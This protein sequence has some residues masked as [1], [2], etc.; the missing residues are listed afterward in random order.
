MCDDVDFLCQNI[1]EHIKYHDDLEFLGYCTSASGCAKM[2]KRYNPDVLLLDIQ[3]ESEYAGIEIIPSLLEE[4]SDL[5]IIVMSSY[6]YSDYI[7]HAIV[8]GAVDYIT[9]DCSI[10]QIIEKIYD[11]YNNKSS[12][13]PEISQ[14]FTTMSRELNTSHKSL[15]YMLNIVITLSKTEFE[16]LKLLCTGM[17][18][19]EIAKM[20]YTEVSTVRSTCSNILKK[21]HATNMKSLVNS[22]NELHVFDYFKDLEK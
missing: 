7:F 1:K 2:I 8:N 5:K 12:L 21:F 20:R 10:E 17:S 18:N 14:K 22:I 3:L 16:I 13:M 9:K 11:A 19:N 6:S 15:I 4:K